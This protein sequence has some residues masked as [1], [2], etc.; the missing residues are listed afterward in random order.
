MPE[1]IDRTKSKKK[2]RNE[3][4]CYYFKQSKIFLEKGVQMKGQV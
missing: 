3:M 4:I 1:L 2:T